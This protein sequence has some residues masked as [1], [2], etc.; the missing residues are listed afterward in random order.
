MAHL[1]VKFS[2]NRG[3]NEHQGWTASSNTI[4]RTNKKSQK[5]KNPRIVVNDVLKYLLDMM[6]TTISVIETVPTLFRDSC[7]ERT[8][9][10]LI[11]VALCSSQGLL[12]VESILMQL[13]EGITDV[14]QNAIQVRSKS[15]S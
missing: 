7:S 10:L 11:A 13:Q 15:K 12:H 2:I 4:K 1:I 8:S 3:W 5:Q 6:N 9:E 14:E